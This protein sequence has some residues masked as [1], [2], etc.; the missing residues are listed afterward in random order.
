ML[1]DADRRTAGSFDPGQPRGVPDLCA[2]TGR[3]DAERNCISNIHG[4]GLG[5]DEAASRIAWLIRE[6]LARG[7][8]GVGAQG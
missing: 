8:T 3:T 1:A 7:V 5:H 6:G 4:A 2:E